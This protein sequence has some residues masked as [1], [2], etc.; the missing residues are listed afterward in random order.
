MEPVSVAELKKHLRLTESADTIDESSISIA[1]VE[2]G[3]GAVTGAPVEVLYERA[4]VAVTP[5][6]ISPTASIVLKIQE[7][8]SSAT[9]FTDWYTFAAQGV[10]WVDPLVKE[11]TGQKSYIRVTAAVTTASALFG[12]TVNLMD[13]ENAEDEYLGTLIQTAREMVEFE[14]RR[15]LLTQERTYRLKDF[16]KD[17]GPI[18]LPFGNLQTADSI[19]YTDSDGVETTMAAEAYYVQNGGVYAS[20]L[21]PAHGTDWPD[22]D[23]TSGE[24][25]LITFTCGYGDDPA[26]VPSALRTAI[27]MLCSDLYYSR[28]EIVKDARTTVYENKTV[29]RILK[30]YDMKRYI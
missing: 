19:V 25:I 23:P 18:T 10:A 29:Q 2:H 24:G 4:I 13:T 30:Q 22:Y 28:G 8:D 3:I 27:K 14:T 15:A 12:A 17:D 26:D 21:F 5:G 20:T 1:F 7:S 9:G 11:Y 16:P 6:T